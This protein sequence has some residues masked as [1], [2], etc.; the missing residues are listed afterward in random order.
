MTCKGIRYTE[1][2]SPLTAQLELTYACNNNCIYCYNPWRNG[3][4]KKHDELPLE[5]FRRIIEK[6]G[7]ADLF[8]LVFT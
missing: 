3:E 6:L 8:E 1:I 2:K 7:D 5:K 4:S